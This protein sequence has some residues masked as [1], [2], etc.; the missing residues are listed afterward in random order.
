MTVDGS[1]EQGRTERRHSSNETEQQ[2]Q[3]ILIVV[4]VIFVINS[5]DR[6]PMDVLDPRGIV[7]LSEMLE[8]LI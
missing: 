7:C 2:I 5:P 8:G 3:K 4:V 6:R 1:R